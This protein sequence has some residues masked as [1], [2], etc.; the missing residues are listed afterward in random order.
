[1]FMGIKEVPQC[2]NIGS[3]RKKP[4]V[5]LYTD[6][7]HHVRIPKQKQG[8]LLSLDVKYIWTKSTGFT[9]IWS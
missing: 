5:I 3:G 4:T 1:M 9:V 6:I 8:T 2:N 7:N